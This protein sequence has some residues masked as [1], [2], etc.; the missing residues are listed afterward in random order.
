MTTSTTFTPT[1]AL[2]A[3]AF[4]TATVLALLALAVG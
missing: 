4:L 3:L 2:T 1:L